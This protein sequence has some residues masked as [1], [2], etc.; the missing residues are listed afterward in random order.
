MRWS[1]QT[2]ERVEWPRLE[3]LTCLGVYGP[4]VWV[5]GSSSG[6]VFVSQD[7][8]VRDNLLRGADTN[9]LGEF[10]TIEVSHR[11]GVYWVEPAPEVGWLLTGSF[12]IGAVQGN[13]VRVWEPLSGREVYRLAA[14]PAT[15][16]AVAV[17]PRSTRFAIAFG[18]EVEVWPLQPDP[19]TASARA[20]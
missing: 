10:Q 7:E 2:D 6:Q 19:P 8:F 1:W 17:S 16:S 11:G 20:Q 18:D 14:L 15:L 9:P 12:D 3:P 13:E 5:R 4:G